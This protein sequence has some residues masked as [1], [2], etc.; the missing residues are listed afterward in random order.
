MAK[1]LLGFVLI[2][3]GAFYV[4]VGAV[5]GAAI[6][7]AR[8]DREDQKKDDADKAARLKESADIHAALKYF[9]PRTNH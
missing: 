9:R 6:A 1:L 8:R 5:F 4:L 2:T 3:I 7:N